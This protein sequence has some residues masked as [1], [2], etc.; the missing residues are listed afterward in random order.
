MVLDLVLSHLIFNDHCKN[1]E[2]T[3]SHFILNCRAKSYFRSFCAKYS[4]EHENMQTQYSFA[5]NQEKRSNIRCGWSHNY[6]WY[7]LLHLL[8]IIG[9]LSEGSQDFTISNSKWTANR[10]VLLRIN[11]KSNI[12]NKK[13]PK[14]F[15]TTVGMW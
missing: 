2:A 8:C 13:L 12:N 9:L 7:W 10:V 6:G 3:L 11:K 15:I 14:A 5:L 4:S 1:V